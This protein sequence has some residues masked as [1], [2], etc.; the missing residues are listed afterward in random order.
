MP[1][2]V[3]LDYEYRYPSQKAFYYF[4][5]AEH[6]WNLR[7]PSHYYTQEGV[8]AHELFS[9]YPDFYRTCWV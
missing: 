9:F 8:L 7:G 3:V 5:Q 4:G 2:G 1:E 6:W